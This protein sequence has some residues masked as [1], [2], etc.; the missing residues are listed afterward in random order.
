MKDAG[1]EEA[2]PMAGKGVC[3]IGGLPCKEPRGDCPIRI[4]RGEKIA[5]AGKQTA[6]V[7][8]GRVLGYQRGWGPILRPVYFEETDKR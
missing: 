8:Q 3:G 6:P 5:G 1:R 2:C 7:P 4:R